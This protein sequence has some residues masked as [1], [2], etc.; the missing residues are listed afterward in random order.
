MQISGRMRASAPVRIR[1]IR[2]LTPTQ[3]K[4]IRRMQKG[5]VSVRTVK[6]P[7]LAKMP[8][9]TSRYGAFTSQGMRPIIVGSGGF[10]AVA[11]TT[12]VTVDP[13]KTA[14]QW[15]QTITQLA[16]QGLT[17]YQAERLRKEN[18]DRIR[19]GLP[20]LTDA[21]MRSLAPTANVNVALPPAIQ[22]GALAGG[23]ALLYLLA[24]SK[25]RR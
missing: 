20:P 24:T 15:L 12:S 14:P 7:P 10:G 25:K 6:A 11:P 19:Q 1:A 9:Y 3:K 2:G 8:S 22:Y 4:N 21:Q 13:T 17:I 16:S 23:A 18:L 5:T